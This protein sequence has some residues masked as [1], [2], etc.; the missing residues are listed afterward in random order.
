MDFGKAVLLAGG[1]DGPFMR[2]VVCRV[3]GALPP[4]CKYVHLF[5]FYKQCKYA[6]TIFSY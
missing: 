1:G 3:C 2:A 6:I 5:L 4:D